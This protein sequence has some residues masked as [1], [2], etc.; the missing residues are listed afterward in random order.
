VLKEKGWEI[1]NEAIAEGIKTVTSRTG[2]KGR[3]QVLGNNPTIICDTAHNLDGMKVVLQ[4]LKVQ[5]Y[6]KLF[7]VFGMLKGKDVSS[8]LELLPVE[9]YYFFCQATIPRA[10]D[11]QLLFQQADRYELRGEVVADVN[12]AI[13]NAKRVATDNDL[14]FVGGST[15]VVAE[16]ENL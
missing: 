9:A 14:I 3:W 4:Q 12:E 11:A 1:S 5:Q 7:F 2:L 15:Y 6:D 10:L 16:I 13:A 8:I